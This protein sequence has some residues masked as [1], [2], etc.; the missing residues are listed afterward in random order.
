MNKEEFIA[1]VS[2]YQF[3]FAHYCS[4]RQSFC[5]NPENPFRYDKHYLS[6][7][8]DL[9]VH[10]SKVPQGTTIADVITWSL[11]YGAYGVNVIKRDPENKN[12]LRSALIG[13]Y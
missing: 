8:S 1:I 10:I 13:S 11:K 4:L 6:K 7:H 12:L 2:D 9:I 5:R 3:E